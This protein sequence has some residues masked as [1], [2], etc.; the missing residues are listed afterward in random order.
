MVFLVEEQLS[1]VSDI[2]LLSLKEKQGKDSCGREEGPG[3]DSRDAGGVESRAWTVLEMNESQMECLEK[4]M[5]KSMGEE[6]EGECYC[7]KK[8]CSR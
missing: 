4:I 3:K 8:G 6:L 5:S 2:S 1:T 7:D